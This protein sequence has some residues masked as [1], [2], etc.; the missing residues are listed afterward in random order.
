MITKIGIKKVASYG[1]IPAILETN[2]KIN[3]VY[4]LNG[5]GKTVFSN[6]LADRKGEDFLDCTIEGLR[7]E[8][9]LVYNQN[10]I[11]KNFYQKDIQKGIFTLSSENKKAEEE[12]TKAEEEITK[13]NLQLEN[14]ETQQGYNYDLKKK[15]EEITQLVNSSKEKTWEIKTTYSGGDRILE[16]CLEG[17]RGKQED[18][19]NHIL[20]I[21]KLENEPEKTIE[22]LKEEAEATQGVNAT[23]Y[24]E[25]VI[26]KTNFDFSEIEKENIFTEIIVGNEN[27]AI[28]SLIKKL[29]NAD[30]VKQGLDYLPNTEEENRDYSNKTIQE[31]DECPFCQ[32][33]TITV[34][35][36]RQM[37]DY[38]DKTYQN[39]ITKLNDLDSEYFSAWQNVKNKEKLF[40]ENPFIKNKEKE[41]KLIYK[42]FTEKLSNNW[43]KINKKIKNPSEE[44]ILELTIL[45]KNELNDFLDEII[46]ETKTHNLKIKNKEQTK[47][48]IV[49]AFWQIMRWDYDQTIENYK[50]QKEKFKEEK[51]KIENY[52]S[53]LKIENDKQQD[54]KKEVQKEI[55]NIDEAIDNINTELKFLG[56]DGFRIEKEGD[57]FYKIKRG[58]KGKAQFETLSEGEKTIISFLYFLELCKGKEE[59]NEVSTEKIVVIDDP[60]SS[61]SHIYVFNV[62]QLIKKTFFNN[63]Y[64]QIFILTHSL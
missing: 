17:N 59:K 47:K 27:I 11:K 64:K 56:A 40:L 25:N 26:Q 45:E 30:W 29:G 34:E 8:K 46:E 18:L 53:E 5:A 35:L 20:S 61:L 24:D 3:L 14:E 7:D 42:N 31:K 32:N 51:K 43:S 39:K 4:G 38:F 57:N 16:F 28:A 54:I 41:F 22:I 15:E 52:I 55:I 60:I 58:N 48:E 63:N 10:F 9:M 33:K 50:S 12:I 23:T 2:K 1:E 21:T 36:Q 6:Y 49:H 37:K 13:I 62:A 19:F 44:I